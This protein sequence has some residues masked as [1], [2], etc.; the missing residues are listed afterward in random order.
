MARRKDYYGPNNK[1]VKDGMSIFE[2]FFK[3]AIWL[4]TIIVV[5]L[6]D[7]TKWAYNSYQAKKNKK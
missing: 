7:L 3:V 2:G 6:I 5:G 4:G 1:K